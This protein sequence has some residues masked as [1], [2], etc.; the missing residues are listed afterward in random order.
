MEGRFLLKTYWAR[1]LCSPPAGKLWISGI[2][3]VE[4][5][6]FLIFDEI[7]VI[8]DNFCRNS[9]FTGSVGLIIG[10]S[11]SGT[12]FSSCLASSIYFSIRKKCIFSSVQLPRTYCVHFL[13]PISRPCSMEKVSSRMVNRYT[14]IFD[15][16][17]L[18]QLLVLPCPGL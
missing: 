6:I 14:R 17:G 9:S 15:A 5:L 7:C 11:R 3:K 10:S 12:C 13:R 16:G 4:T 18:T 1:R 2:Q 8:L